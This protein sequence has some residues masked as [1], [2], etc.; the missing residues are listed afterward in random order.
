MTWITCVFHGGRFEPCLDSVV[1]GN[2]EVAR[3][4]RPRPDGH[5][6]RKSGRVM[7]GLKKI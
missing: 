4:H 7:H 6:M 2:R 1:R 3:L 5:H